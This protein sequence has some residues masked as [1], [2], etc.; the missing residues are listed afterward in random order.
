[1]MFSF[2]N[3]EQFISVV[4]IHIFAVVSPGPDFAVV[5]KQSIKYGK[6]S[7]LLTSLGISFG[8][9]VHVFYCLIGVG[10]IIS[11][12][13]Y[14]YNFLKIAGAIY[15]SYLG[16]STFFTK[17]G[18]K[19]DSNSSNYL[20]K[21][22]TKP[23][24]VGFLT[25]IFNP[26]ATLFFISLFSLVIDSETSIYL[27]IFYGIWMALITCLWFCLVSLLISSYYLKMFIT[28][29]SFT[30]DKIMGIVLIMISIK[31]LFL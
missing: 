23:F 12:N 9:L 21:Y 22:L 11:K 17:P 28:K 16:I 19:F 14:L 7:S 1:M 26:K 25:N 3:I 6:K 4:L 30:I 5:I 31:I 15:L 27:Q 24:I 20:D 13:I 10:L 18:N 29:Y 8:I 2:I